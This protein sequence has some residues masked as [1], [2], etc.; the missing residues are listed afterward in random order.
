MIEAT[1]LIQS[2][3]RS[4]SDHPV[5]TSG[6]R[7]RAGVLILTYLV[8]VFI[9]AAL[10]APWIYMAAQKFPAAES[11]ADL[12]PTPFYRYISRL[13]LV[14]GLAGLYPLLRTLGIQSLNG[15]GT[16]PSSSRFR[17]WSN[18]FF[19]GLL[20]LAMVAA[21][22]IFI[23][24]RTLDFNHDHLEWAAHWRGVFLTALIVG[25]IEEILFRGAL[26]GGLRKSHRFWTAAL[27]SSVIYALLHFLGKPENPKV[28]EWA[29]GF[30]VLG[31]M[32]AGVFEWH[33]LLPAVI[34]LTLLGLIL[35]AAFERTGALFLSLG[36][37]MG[38]IICAKTFPFVT[39][40]NAA[41][42]KNWIWGSDKL[43]DGWF[44]TVA[45]LLLALVLK[46]QFPSKREKVA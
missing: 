6:R 36:L 4:K 9:G 12:V 17:E 25:L 27:I 32:T 21:G 45:L 16:T 43:V 39:Q 1:S 42:T 35:A 34:N 24:G 20:L 29:S 26:F 23:G 11:T 10:I 40:A 7:V 15:L 8:T 30:V 22:S 19:W 31:K 38:L 41:S 46:I 18:G 37:H 13:L 14:L 2:A 3:D 5:R 33:S 44:A 28:M